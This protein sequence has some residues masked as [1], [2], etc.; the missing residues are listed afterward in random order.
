V[1]TAV[2]LLSGYAEF[3]KRDTRISAPKRPAAAPEPLLRKETL[4]EVEA[5]QILSRY[6]IPV[7]GEAV[8]TD[9][10]AAVEAAERLGYPVVMKVVSESILHKTEVGGVAV[11]VHDAAAVRST[12]EK[13][14]AVA[15]RVAG[16][17]R[18]DGVLVQEQVVGG[19]EMIAG[20]KVDAQFG[21]FVMLGFGGV[22]TEL[23]KDVSLRSAPVTPA[24][25]LEMLRELRGASLL[26]GFRGAQHLD[27]D[28]LAAAV[29]GLSEFAADHA[30]EISEVDLN[31]V[32]VLPAGRGVRV[33]DAVIVPAATPK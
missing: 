25:A 32:I 24:T 20:I 31:P 33:V 1:F 26:E 29:A 13:L 5:R 10:A 12:F 9:A 17:G 22:F 8:V 7:P 30:T 3:R 19:V 21:P 27:V 18:F 4:T 15:L 14:R 11:G 23:L 28:A 2:R 6:G 16:E